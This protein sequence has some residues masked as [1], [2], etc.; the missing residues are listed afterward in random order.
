M[1]RFLFHGNSLQLGNKG[2]AAALD[3][4]LF[5][6]LCVL[7]LS[8][9]FI[10]S[11]K[12]S[13]SESFIMENENI[14]EV[15]VR[16][17]DSL[18][19]SAGGELKIKTVQPIALKEVDSCLSNDIR[20]IMG[21]TDDA[22]GSLDEAE[23]QLKNNGF[24]DIKNNPYLLYVKA[25]ISDIES[26]LANIGDLVSTVIT[27]QFEKAIAAA[28]SV[29]SVIDYLSSLLPGYDDMSAGCSG[30][31][32][33]TFLGDLESAVSE[34]AGLVSDFQ[35]EFERQLEELDSLVTEQL[36]AL[37]HEIRCALSAVKDSA[38][39]LLTYVETGLNTQVSIMEL[40]PVEAEVKGMTIEKMLS[41]SVKA[42]SRFAFADEARSTASIAG[43]MALR[44]HNITSSFLD[45]DLIDSHFQ[46]DDVKSQTDDIILR[47]AAPLSR[48]D[49]RSAEGPYQEMVFGA[50]AYLT[51]GGNLALRLQFSSDAI[52]GPKHKTE[53]FEGLD[54]LLNSSAYAGNTHHRTY[55]GSIVKGVVEEDRITKTVRTWNE[56]T[57]EGDMPSSTKYTEYKVVRPMAATVHLEY[58]NGTWGEEDYTFDIEH[59]RVCGESDYDDNGS[60]CNES[61]ADAMK[62]V[63]LGTISSGRGSLGG[64]LEDAIKERLDELLEGYEY[65]F[66]A[67]DCC[68]PIIGINPGKEPEGRPGEAKRYFIA[69]SSRGE[70]RLIVWRE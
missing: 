56:T 62:S 52:G 20:T 48:I 30:L 24:F 29:C 39:S 40:L 43:L 41:D 34:A 2:Q 22:I 13:S 45:T 70:M 49:N 33:S 54:Y 23:K 37:I 10:E 68:R 18:A 53:Y 46:A 21:H 58:G 69:G 17:M 63:V 67:W 35:N 7:S 38:S 11:A 31:L 5:V 65:R 60:E 50:Q 15:A 61:D 19:R 55:N 66:E 28:E 12:A 51:P 36:V 3:L 57:T 9:L 16:A 6:S 59:F 1:A 8:Y 64:A 42:G 32:K 27:E 4:A 25:R 26:Y 44:G 14:N 47:P